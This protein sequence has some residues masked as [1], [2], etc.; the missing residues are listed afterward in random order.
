MTQAE[1]VSRWARRF[2]FTGAAFLVLWQLAAVTGVGRRAGVVLGLLGF[3]F[4]TVFGKAYSLVP[5]YFDRDL[6]TA[7]LMPLHLACS[8]A[9]TLLLA[10]GAERT[11]EAAS[12]P[13]AVLWVGGVVVFVGTLLTTV[14]DNLT[15]AETGTGDHNADRRRLDRIAN[16]GVPAALAYLS[17]GSYE[18]LAVTT[19]IPPL[20]DG[21]VPRAFHLLAV[22]A[23]ALFVFA[24]GF[25]LLPRF[26]A[27]TPPER[28]ALLV[29]PAGIVAPPLLA[30]GVPSGGLLRAGALLQSVAFVGYAAVV[31]TLFY[32]TDR[33]RI[34]IYGV[35]GG[36]VA[37][38]LGIAL[39]LHFAFGDGVASLVTAHR[40]LNVLGFLGLTV[41][42]VSYQFYPPGVV[43]GRVG[44]ETVGVA[45]IGCL[46]GALALEL[47]GAAV[48]DPLVRVGRGLALLGSVLHLWLLGWIFRWRYGDS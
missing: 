41:V 28:L 33:D 23:G 7:R 17:A 11:V 13:G 30:A 38:V 44:G 5:T 26:L 40:R 21:Y 42:G 27:T 9:G 14:R 47:G 32:R 3:V 25:R 43:S 20:F 8:V 37:G 35:V 4:H 15:G 39:G 12:V 24:V 19:D 45:A 36:A 22:G 6:V 31:A 18:L 46:A 16:L 2:V 1:R 34:G 48:S 29:L 10:A